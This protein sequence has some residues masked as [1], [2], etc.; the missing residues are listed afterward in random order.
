MKRLVRP[1]PQAL[2]ESN[3][4]WLRSQEGPFEPTARLGA[5]KQTPNRTDERVGW[6]Q[7]VYA[8]RCRWSTEEWTRISSHRSIRR[9]PV[10]DRPFRA[11]L[12]G[13]NRQKPFRWR[14][15]R[16]VRIVPF[17]SSRSDRPVRIVP[18]GSSRSDRPVRIVPFQ[19]SR[20]NRPVPTVPFQPSRSNRP[21]RTGA[22]GTEQA[23]AAV[24]RRDERPD[25]RRRP[26]ADH[27]T[28][29]GL[30]GRT[31]TEIEGKLLE[32]TNVSIVD[33]CCSDCLRAPGRFHSRISMLVHRPIQSI[34]SPGEFRPR[35]TR[36]A[37][38]SAR[39]RRNPHLMLLKHSQPST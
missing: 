38:A 3:D 29:S 9:A 21:G 7:P 28:V 32:E 27:Q 37:G 13:G 12:T 36:N 25:E 4:H 14:P 19:P 18:F 15:N 22:D 26:A 24:R 17:G 31:G 34:V 5:A 10:I 30:I 8:S 20:S 39:G 16:P 35:H 6:G 2:R 11:K 33:A 1:E 23:P